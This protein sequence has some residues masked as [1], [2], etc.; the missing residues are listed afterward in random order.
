MINNAVIH[1]FPGSPYI[2][3]AA[4][5]LRDGDRIRDRFVLRDVDACRRFLARVYPGIPSRVIV[6]REEGES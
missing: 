6:H 3:K 4:V 1:S 2:V 5:N